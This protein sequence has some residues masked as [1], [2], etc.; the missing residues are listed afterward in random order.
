MAL[1][2]DILY[3]ADCTDWQEAAR[4]VESAVADL[5][6]EA[7]VNYWLIEN[8][9]QAL[10]TYFVGSPTIRINGEDLFPVQGATAGKRLRSYLT[11][12]G[13]S[14]HPTYAMILN[15]LRSYVS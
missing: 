5:G 3:T 12:E 7:E 9:R 6:V 11:E 1:R 4:L 10:Q 8:D 13:I 14:G 2:V 15:A